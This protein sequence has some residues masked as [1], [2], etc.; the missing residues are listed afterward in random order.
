MHHN[1][2]VNLKKKKRYGNQCYLSRNEDMEKLDEK[3]W[4]S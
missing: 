1:L 3:I 2:K 4:I